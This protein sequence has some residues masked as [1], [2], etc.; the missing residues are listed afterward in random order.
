MEERA[1]AGLEASG[2]RA[3]TAM[4]ERI[5]QTLAAAA[6]DPRERTAL[7]EGRLSREVAPAGFDVFA[8]TMRALRLVAR[9]RPH[10]PARP[11][12]ASALSDDPQRRR[13]R[14]EVR[15]RTALTAARTKL[16]RLEARATASE[17]AAA[18]G[19]Q[20]AAAAR[21]RADVA[22]Q[23]AEDAKTAVRQAQE[24][25]AAA[26]AALGAVDTR[27]TPGSGRPPGPG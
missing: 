20:A 6:A 13:A 9:S 15:L 8:P 16:R 10:P 11:V 21:R 24:E 19:A 4:R 27:P 23:V 3:T 2:R 17:A 22:S 7:R 18:R 25:L 12:S 5:R 14:E 26:E 1:V